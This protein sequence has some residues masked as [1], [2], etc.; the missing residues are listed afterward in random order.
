MFDFEKMNIE[1]LVE[2]QEKITKQVI[3]VAKKDGLNTELLQEL[4][5]QITALNDRLEVLEQQEPK[6]KYLQINELEKINIDTEHSEFANLLINLKC[7]INVLL[8]GEAGSGKTTGAHNVAKALNLNFASISVGQ[9]TGKHEFFGFIDGH[10]HFV[11]TEFYTTYKNGGVFLIDELDAGN[12]GVLTSINSALANGSCA[13]ACGMVEKHENFIC[14]ATANTYGNGATL[15]FVGRN[16]I[17]GATLDRFV[18]ITW[19]IDSILEQKIAQSTESYNLILSI[20][21]AC[22]KLNIRHIVSTRALI[23]Y[24]KLTSAGMDTENALKM[25]VWKGI[26]QENKALILNNL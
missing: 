6:T 15:D 8:V 2:V 13:F 25:S 17:D 26:S 16:A 12:A 18:V 23:N 24:D 14:V 11:E 22:K 3:E 10:G 20:R 4:N 19:N 9:Q 7:K 1:E 5:S 21:N